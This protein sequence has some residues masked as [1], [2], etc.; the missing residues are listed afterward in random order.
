M[1]EL[2]AAV[3]DD[4]T[5]S[6]LTEEHLRARPITGTELAATG[7]P[8]I[9]GRAPEGYVIP[10]FGLDGKLL[11]YYR[12]RIL[13][14]M[15][16]QS[17]KYRAPKGGMNHIY[18]PPDLPGLLTKDA[19]WKAIII[20]EGEKKAACAVAHGFPCVAVSGVDCWRN[21]Q[22]SLPEDTILKKGKDG[23]IHAKIPSGDSNASVIEGG[24]TLA[25]GMEGLIEYILE[26]N[27]QVIIVYDSDQKGLKP[28]V[29]RAAAQ[30]GYE[31]R[32][33][34][35]PISRIRLMV[36]P[37]R[38]DGSKVGL[39]DYLLSKGGGRERLVKRLRICMARRIAFPRHPNPK[40]YVAS[41]MQKHRLSRKECQDVALAI[42]MELEAR[43][44]RLQNSD[45][46]DM[47]YFDEETHT[48][49]PVFLSNP[50]VMLHETMFGSYLYR[51]FNLSAGDQRVVGWLAAQFNGEPG[52]EQA[53]MHKVFARPNGAGMQNSIAYQFSDTH[54]IIV[55][56][57]PDRP[58]QICENGKYG[59][60]F[61][62]GQVVPIDRK[63]LDTQLVHALEAP[64]DKSLWMDVFKGFNF[65]ESATDQEGYTNASV[66]QLRQLASLLYYLSPWFNRWKGTQLPI[67]LLIGE[68]GSGKSSLYELRQGILTG[69]PR[70]SN[71]TNDIKDWYAGITSRGGIHVLDNVHFTGG[72]KDYRQ[73]L[74]DEYCRL[75]TESTPHVEMRK[76]YTTS[77]V[78]A[79]PV[80]TTFALTA[81][82]QPFYSSDLLQRSAIFEV[83]AI[84]SSHDARWTQRQI[85]N[86]GGRI[87]WVAHHLV[88]MHRFLKLAVWSEQW[89]NHYKAQHR[90]ANYEQALMM[91]AKVLQIDP[92][93]IPDV[94][95]KQTST[96]MSEADWVMTGLTD[97]VQAFKE[98]NEKWQ[99]VRFVVSDITNWCETHENHN[100]NGILVNSRRLG[101][102]IRSHSS[103]IAQAQGI[104]QDGN[105]NNR[106]AY[107]VKEI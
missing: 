57:N 66:E 45:T 52:V 37:G 58:F 39:D 95:S 31:L 63:D 16:A 18:F 89:D 6:G 44:K 93:W 51:E 88:V 104:H 1:A 75:T 81:I 94:L 35:V 28:A 24:G 107:R 85:E 59:V 73:R 2:A 87:G 72:S 61:E 48:L 97:F 34:G 96:Q 56:P 3:A 23:S 19:S 7:S 47:Y 74:S 70:L 80:N 90:L 15:G 42:L 32:Y 49:M 50:R 77:D 54:F 43:G 9:G 55:G 99:L 83:Q 68:P 30:L 8:S 84:S 20:T 62:Q 17:V 91:M 106:A 71:M 5:R 13:E 33:R 14:L 38:S 105:I 65:I 64:K 11:P 29:Q 4:L 41:R 22:I 46:K 101:K 36:L 67:E 92:E 60:L 76:L 82:E 21:R 10:Y 102:Y 25:V 79:L 103:M 26:H 98:R 78:L 40:T 53:T 12:I 27:M 69:I 86:G 100:K